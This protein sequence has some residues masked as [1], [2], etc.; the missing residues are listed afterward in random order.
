MERNEY[1]AYRKLKNTTPTPRSPWKPAQPKYRAGVV[2]VVLAV[3]FLVLGVLEVAGIKDR[4]LELE[5]ASYC[6][7][8]ALHKQNPE[9]G[10]PDYAESADAEC[11]EDGT[12]KEQR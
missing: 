12:V 3:L 10:W 11:N 7:M 9:L 6:R 5:Q 1:D 8:V 4:T 2:V